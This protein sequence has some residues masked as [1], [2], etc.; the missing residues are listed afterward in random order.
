MQRL[1]AL[2][3]GGAVDCTAG[4]AETSRPA[5]T[6]QYPLTPCARSLANNIVV[7]V[8]DGFEKKMELFGTGY[9]ASVAGSELTLNL[10]YS[11]PRILE[12]PKG[13][14][15]QVGGADRRKG[16]IGSSNEG[17]QARRAG[18]VRASAA[19]GNQKWA[20]PLAAH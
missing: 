9:R 2:C 3:V 1:A 4:R 14:K 18:L 19:D 7:G 16:G 17:K 10:G 11:K 13:I 20:A 5:L 8:S 6:V 12:V 15:V